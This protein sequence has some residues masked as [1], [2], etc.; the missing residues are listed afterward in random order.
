MRALAGIPFTGF[1][2]VEVAPAYDT[3]GQVTAL[4]GATVAFEMLALLAVSRR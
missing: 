4:A 3:A 2:V 1:D